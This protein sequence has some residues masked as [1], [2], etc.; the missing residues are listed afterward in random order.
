MCINSATVLLNEEKKI[1]RLYL[2][3][4]STYV[5]YESITRICLYT[6]ILV[7]SI[8][9]RRK[10]NFF[11][12]EIQYTTGRQVR[13]Q[14]WLQNACMQ[15]MAISG[16]T[17]CVVMQMASGSAVHVASYAPMRAQASPVQIRCWS[18]W[19]NDSHHVQI[20]S[21]VFDLGQSK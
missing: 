4:P 15:G 9:N 7:K 10:Y 16:I 17:V 20:Q 19:A 2:N 5:G 13:A 14:R 3:I 11:F 12:C 18:G 1:C 8:M 21:S 6:S